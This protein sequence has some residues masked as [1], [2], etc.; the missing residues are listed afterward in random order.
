[1]PR[2]RAGNGPAGGSAT[3]QVIAAARART[4]GPV[5]VAIVG[6]GAGTLACYSEP[7][8]DWTLY[9]IDPVVVAIARDPARFT[10]LP[11]CAPDLPIVLGDARLTLG[12]A[13]DGSY[14]VILIDA[15]NSD[16]MP[17]HLMTKEAMATYLRKLKP[18]GIVALHVSSRY[19]ELVSVVA[20]IAHA[21]GLIAR[22]A[23][24]NPGA[25][26]SITRVVPSGV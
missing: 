16:T 4:G 25:S 9:E 7:G 17:V 6:L 21:N 20:G 13:P 8:D 5:S 22:I 14:D 23:S 24:A 11:S 15:F 1:M 2:R 26:R 3:V 12:D 10:Y 18:G 19:M